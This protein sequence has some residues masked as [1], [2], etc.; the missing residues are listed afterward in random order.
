MQKECVERKAVEAVKLYEGA[1]DQ[2]NDVGAMNY[3]AIVLQSG[4]RM[5]VQEI[6]L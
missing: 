3:L 5:C 4:G 1:I 2:D 6:N